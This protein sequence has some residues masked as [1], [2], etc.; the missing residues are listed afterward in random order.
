MCLYSYSVHAVT[1]L[2]VLLDNLDIDVLGDD[3]DVHVVLRAGRVEDRA[4]VAA[5]VAV[6]EYCGPTHVI[7]LTVRVI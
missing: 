7:L 6:N 4:R 2:Y 1:F 5:P 3:L